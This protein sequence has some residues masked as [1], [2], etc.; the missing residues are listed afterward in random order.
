[1]S[2]RTRRGGR[3]RSAAGRRLRSL[4]AAL[5]GAA[6]L[7]AALAAGWSAVSTRTAS[8]RFPFPCLGV[9]GL[10]QHVHPWLRIEVDG[11]PVT[12]PAAVGIVDPVYRN[13]AAVGGACFEPLHT[14]DASGIIHLES[15]SPTQLYTLGDFFAVWQATYGTVRIGGRAFP[16]DYTGRELLGHLE[17]AS[18]AIILLVDGRPDSRGPRLPLNGL[19]YCSAAVGRE[20]PCWPTAPQD[21]YPPF[22][23]LRYGTGHTIVLVYGSTRQ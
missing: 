13:G 16:V 15:P 19:D 21:P 8:A 5:G 23:A 9:E 20:P 6:L 11:Q 10:A 14:H 2:G 7:A 17:N 12:I 18:S 4:G 3:G 22:L 1:M